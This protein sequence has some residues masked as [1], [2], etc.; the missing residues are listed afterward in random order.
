MWSCREKPH[1][2]KL[3][4]HWSCETQIRDQYLD[5]EGRWDVEDPKKVLK[6]KLNNRFSF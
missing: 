3:K 1:L 2:V 5:K 4:F 6:K